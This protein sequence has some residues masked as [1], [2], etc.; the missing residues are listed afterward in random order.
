[1]NI[2]DLAAV[3]AKT[4][5]LDPPHPAGETTLRLMYGLPL[6][7][8][9]RGVAE[10]IT[11]MSWDALTQLE[12][13]DFSEVWLGPGRRS[14][15]TALICALPAVFEA[16]F[17]GHEAD[18][19]PGERA[20]IPIISKDIAG[21]KL[22]TRFCC[23]YLDCLGIKYERGTMGNVSL[24]K[25]PGGQVDIAC[26]ANRSD[27]PRGYAMP[28]VVLDEIAHWSNEGANPDTEILAA[29]RPA[30]AQFKRRKLIAASSP[31]AR[32]GVHYETI[33]QHFGQS[34]GSTLALRGATWIWNPRISKE[35]THELEPDPRVHLREYAAIPQGSVSAALDPDQVAACFRPVPEGTRFGVPVLILDP[36]SLRG[37]SF[38]ACVARWLHPGPPMPKF[39]VTDRGAHIVMRDE[40]GEIIREPGLP[41]PTLLFSAIRGWDGRQAATTTMEAIVGDL[42]RQ[43]KAA[44]IRLV[45]SDQREDAALGGLFRH[46]GIYGFRSIAWSSTNKVEAIAQ[47]RRQLSEGTIIISEHEQMRQQLL[48]LEERL[49]PGGSYGY[50]ARRGAHDDYA[51]LIITAMLAE[52]RRGLSDSPLLGTGGRSEWTGVSSIT[53]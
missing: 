48:G 49:L 7:E 5:G 29:I 23:T 21:A 50:G 43:C 52:G 14:W 19:M 8:H 10:T 38:T 26:L 16:V 18:L 53:G 22:A 45:Y 1:M 32:C 42:A 2:I 20:M 40:S 51:A 24:I 41:A 15:K 30:M 31:L 35:K 3:A 34:T 46:A 36:S 28:C 37:D 25:I 33:E 11:G 39:H 17:G 6:P 9:L 27:A 47:L 44:G 4:P 12:G 13:H